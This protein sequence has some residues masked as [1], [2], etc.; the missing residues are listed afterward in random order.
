M[1]LLRHLISRF[2]AKIDI[3]MPEGFFFIFAK[4]NLRGK[5][6]EN[7]ENRFLLKIGPKIS[8]IKD[9]EF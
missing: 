9:R 7:P 2:L 4:K 8:S 3:I 5:N 6:F 1:K